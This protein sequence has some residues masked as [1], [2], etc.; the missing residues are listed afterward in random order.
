MRSG[1]TMKN[2]EELKIAVLMG[3]FSSEREVALSG[4]RRVAAA[5][6]SLGCLVDEV[7]VRDENF[8]LPVETEVAFLV[9]HGKWGE[10]GGIQSIL[11]KNGIPFTG[12]DSKASRIAFDKVMS[13]ALFRK[14]GLATARDAILQKGNWKNGNTEVS[15]DY[16]LVVKPSRE[17]SSI[18][19]FIVR[20]EEQLKTAILQAFEK[21][22]VI[23]I[24]EFI[25]GPELTV[26][27]LNDRALPVIEIRPK[28]G[29]YDYAN[30]YTEGATDELVPAPID[31]SLAQKVQE[32]ALKAHHI[33]GCRDMSRADFRVDAGGTPYILE[34]NSIP[35]MTGTSLL[36][37]AAA[38]AGIT[39]PH[40]CL[41]LVGR[42][43]ERGG[44]KR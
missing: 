7:D 26:G 44:K 1:K 25:D 8:S 3:G 14:V 28:T 35:G 41:T 16:P 24:E 21:D 22:D 4:G 39:F 20:K 23:L 13:K 37:R 10:D 18:G 5:L 34:V 29:W 38:A 15:L 11:E 36:P 30:K 17:G 27:I 42:A 9:F 43:F 31:F 32:N 19:I 6:R 2:P 40:L 12:S 33:L